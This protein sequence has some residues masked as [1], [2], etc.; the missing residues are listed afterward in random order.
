MVK[1]FSIRLQQNIKQSNREKNLGRKARDRGVYTEFNSIRS[2]TE[3]GVK[4]NDGKHEE[5][6]VII[7]CTGFGY[8]TD[9]LKN[10]T[11]IQQ[12]GQ[13]ATSGTVVK[14]VD[15]LWLVGFGQ[16]TGFASATLSGVGR[17]ARKTVSEI[18]EYLSFLE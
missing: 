15:G 18:K 8:A 7:W 14:D 17:S 2:I 13:I 1:I 12:N 9:Y 11:E 16:W 10:L 3:T 4:W 5:F 6:D